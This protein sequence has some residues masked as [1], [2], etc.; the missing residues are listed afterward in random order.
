MEI[1]TKKIST[2]KIATE[3][4]T[5]E[6]VDDIEMNKDEHEAPLR[7]CQYCLSSQCNSA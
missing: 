5:E 6:V 3:K 4:T 2:E 7:I 1:A